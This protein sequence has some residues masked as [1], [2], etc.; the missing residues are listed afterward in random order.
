MLTV[1]QTFEI[2]LKWVET[3]DWKT[4]FEDAVP[5]RKFNEQG[6]R[7]KGEK[8]AEPAE[9][10]AKPAVVVDAAAMEEDEEAGLEED[11]G[12]LYKGGDDAAMTPE[13]SDTQVATA[14]ELPASAEQTPSI[15][16]APQS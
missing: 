16:G 12:D 6:R 14:S 2:L 7:A 3:R 11:Q 10:A 1:N 13:H 15:L 4:A 8:M 5:K 9:E